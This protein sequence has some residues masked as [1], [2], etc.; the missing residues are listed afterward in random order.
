[1]CDALILWGRGVYTGA[2]VL[3]ER[4]RERRFFGQK[5]KVHYVTNCADSE[6]ILNY[7]A[8]VGLIISYIN[9]R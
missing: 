1:M 4:G 2:Q 8:K 5:R 9:V 7:D 6:G 3:K